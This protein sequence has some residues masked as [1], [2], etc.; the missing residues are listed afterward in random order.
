MNQGIRAL[1]VAS[2]L[3]CSTALAGCV[4]YVNG[5][6]AGAGDDT[7]AGSGNVQKQVRALSGYDEVSIAVPGRIELIQDNTES[8]SVEADDNLQTQIETVVEGRDLKIQP[9]YRHARLDGRH[10]HIVIHLK[11]LKRLDLGGRGDVNASALHASRLSVNLGGSGSVT[12]GDLRADKLSVALGG[13]GSLHATG[14]VDKMDAAIG[15][16]GRIDAGQLKARSVD[17]SIGGSGR[18]TVAAHDELDVTI[19]GSGDIGYYGDPRLSQ[20]TFGSGHVH[21]LGAYPL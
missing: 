18:L 4:V 8:V 13:S 15:G 7:V 16:S 12:F 2:T 5:S 9:L 3:I 1:F 6:D 11:D 19:A 14:S 10:M 20:T 21:R 17:I